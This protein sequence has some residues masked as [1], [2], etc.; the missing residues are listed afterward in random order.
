MPSA[1]RRDWKVTFL[2]ATK[3]RDGHNEPLLTWAPIGDAWAAL[4]FGRGDERRQSAR[5][6]GVQTATF[7]VLSCAMTRGVT[8]EDR[9][10]GDGGEWNVVG[11]STPNR[12]DIEFTVRRVV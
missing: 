6:S 1:G 3:T 9:I 8:I 7:V 11:I 12:A 10:A 5:E 2:R 4:W